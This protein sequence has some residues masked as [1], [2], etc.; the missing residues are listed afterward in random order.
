M[1]TT[2]AAYSFMGYLQVSQNTDRRGR[3]ENESRHIRKGSLHKL[4]QSVI[5]KLIYVTILAPK[6][7]LLTPPRVLLLRSTGEAVSFAYLSVFR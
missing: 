5:M 3:F 1:Q 2:F 6:L 7:E 4:T